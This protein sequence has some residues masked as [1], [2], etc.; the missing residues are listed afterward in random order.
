MFSGVVDYF[1]GTS[2]EHTLAEREIAKATDRVSAAVIA[3]DA[4]ALQQALEDGG[5]PDTT[6]GDE[7]L[8]TT[9]L[10]YACDR[11]ERQL[12]ALLVAKGCSVTARD[13][14]GFS[15]LQWALGG[16]DATDGDSYDAADFDDDDGGTGVVGGRL[17]CSRI[18][19]RALAS[20]GRRWEETRAELEQ[21][22]EELAI[23]VVG[24]QR[25]M[26]E[27]EQRCEELEVDLEN[28]GGARGGSGGGGGG[29]GAGGGGSGAGGGKKLHRW[30]RVRKDGTKELISGA[31]TNTFSPSKSDLK[32]MILHEV[33]DDPDAPGSGPY[34]SPSVPSSSR[35]RARGSD[36]DDGDGGDDDGD[37][38]GRGGRG[39]ATD[40]FQGVRTVQIVS[41]G[42]YHTSP[43][44]IEP[45]LAPGKD[46]PHHAV[47][48][49]YR[50]DHHG[51][52][53]II[54]GAVNETYQPSIDDVGVPVRCSYVPVDASGR[55]GSRL[56]AETD[57]PIVIEPNLRDVVTKQLGG[58]DCV[59]EVFSKEMSRN[60]NLLI[61]SD[62][63]KVRDG[64]TTKL[65]NT[66]HP[67]F[68]VL[69]SAADTAEFTIFFD[70]DVKME[71]K[72]DNARTRDI[73]CLAIRSFCLLYLKKK[74]GKK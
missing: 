63:L 6:I 13:A 64:K 17:A 47:H 53:A 54:A 51:H 48:Q 66:Y 22:V 34:S 52:W 67:D 2:P 21:E 56:Y 72:V 26:L 41:S 43:L 37:G 11:G 8:G 35:R 33:V 7:S 55:K 65:K 58:K 57:G 68:R 20:E 1:T 74:K 44:R 59:Y 28:A 25:A 10:H 12:A 70:K 19:A 15:A 42:D 4:S 36:D 5:D 3:C 16:A 29:S 69:L 62:R 9:A 45:R 46:R 61:F 40:S 60:V 23:R 38:H 49:W 39:G 27:S 24:A 50:K 14:R 71:F 32:V 73:V 30:F 31:T 18:V